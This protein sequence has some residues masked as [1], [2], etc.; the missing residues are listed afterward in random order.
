MWMG[1]EDRV[2][3]GGGYGDGVWEWSKWRGSGV[4]NG[5]RDGAMG[6]HVEWGEGLGD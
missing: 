3:G 1:Y 2:C 6:K 4:E 5:H